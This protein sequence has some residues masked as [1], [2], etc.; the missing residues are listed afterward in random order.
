MLEQMKTT[1]RPLSKRMGAEAFLVGGLCWHQKKATN[2]MEVITQPVMHHLLKV[3]FDVNNL[4]YIV[5]VT[6]YSVL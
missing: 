2:K 6:I 4:I 1:Q 3:K 5:I